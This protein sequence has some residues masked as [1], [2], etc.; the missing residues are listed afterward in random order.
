MFWLNILDQINEF[1]DDEMMND[2]NDENETP[3]MFII[4]S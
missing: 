3:S 2:E 1:E 4:F